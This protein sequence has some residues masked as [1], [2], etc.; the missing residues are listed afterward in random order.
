MEDRELEA[1]AKRLGEGAA[2]A[3][4]PE[5][6]AESVVQRLRAEPALGVRWWRRSGV[7][8]AAAA[9]VL[10]VAAGVFVIRSTTEGRVA[11]AAPAAL[12]ELAPAEL[13]EIID[14]LRVDAPVSD[15]VAPSLDELSEQ[16]LERL[17][18][19]MEG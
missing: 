9:A 15:L 10:V 3:V 18:Q 17:L 2:A 12:Q 8:H 19:E 11:L 1:L 16:Q 4:D 7:A 6:T 14:S 5:R 13:A